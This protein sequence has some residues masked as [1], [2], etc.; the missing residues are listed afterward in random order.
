MLSIQ[1]LCA[2]YHAGD[3]LH[4]VSLH[5]KAGEI[6]GLLG[7]NGAG[8]TTLLM[9]V[10]GERP[11]R[12][13]QV[14]LNNQDITHL[15]THERMRQRLAIVPEGRRIWPHLTVRENLT[16][17]GWQQSK[18]VLAAEL[19]FIFT[20]FPRL[21][22]R[23]NQRGGTLS[24]G[25]Q[26]MLAIGRALCSKPAMLL[27]DEP[28]LGIAPLVAQE[29]FAALKKIN[30]EHGVTLLLVEQNAHAALKLASRGYVLA[31]GKVVLENTSDALLADPHVRDAYLGGG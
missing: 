9:S 8:K 7:A 1:H 4:D 15:P 18:T 26:Q 3:V 17:G 10:C 19:D 2:G 27:L 20:L 16:L 31:G 22:E 11:V 5:I 23:L 30:T 13:G 21:K 24:G 28:S 25:E 14:Q 29:I 6:V 12:Q